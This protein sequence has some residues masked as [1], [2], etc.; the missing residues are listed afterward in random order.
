MTIEVSIPKTHLRRK[1]EGVTKRKKQNRRKG[2]FFGRGIWRCEA[3]FA[4]W[5]SKEFRAIRGDP[6]NG[7]PVCGSLLEYEEV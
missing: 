4:F 6:K 1:E 7:C 3:C 5:T 2:R